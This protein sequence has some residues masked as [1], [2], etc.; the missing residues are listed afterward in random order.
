[1]PKSERHVEEIEKKI[2]DLKGVMERFGDATNDLDRLIITIH[3]PPFTT[4]VDIAFI[5]GILDAEKKYA[6]ATIELNNVL[7][8]AASKIELNPQPLPP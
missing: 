1:M 7:V 4:P 3:K 6:L 2:R 8:S 5:E